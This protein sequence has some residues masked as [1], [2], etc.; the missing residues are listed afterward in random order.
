MQD[1]RKASNPVSISVAPTTRV[2]GKRYFDLA[3]I[4]ELMS[5]LWQESVIDGFEF[6]NLAEW[7]D[8]NPPRDEREKR[9]AAALIRSKTPT[10]ERG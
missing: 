7:D 3:G 5:L 9:L 6:Q 2:I 1:T 10:K 4:I 8:E